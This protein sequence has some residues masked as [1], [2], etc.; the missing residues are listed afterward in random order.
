MLFDWFKICIADH[1]YSESYETTSYCFTFLWKYL[2]FK[3]E[4]PLSISNSVLLVRHFKLN[5]RLETTTFL[6]LKLD[7]N[8]GQICKNQS[9]E[10]KICFL[11]R[12][13]SSLLCLLQNSA[14]LLSSSKNGF[15]VGAAFKTKA[16]S[17]IKTFQCHGKYI[18]HQEI[19]CSASMVHMY[20]FKPAVVETW[21][22]CRN[23]HWVNCRNFT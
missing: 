1:S 19:F 14:T 15:T 6:P 18:I 21:C 17:K 11:I 9:L 8:T 13:H 2:C 5:Y 4:L 22:D 7:N 16:Y 23:Y 20:K 10:K 3:S 12:K